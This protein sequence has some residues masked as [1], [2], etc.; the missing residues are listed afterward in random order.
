MFC[1]F[2]K[3][4]KK[5]THN[6]TAKNGKSVAKRLP[7]RLPRLSL[8]GS[9]RGAV[10]HLGPEGFPRPFPMPRMTSNCPNL[11]PKMQPLTLELSAK[12][13]PPQDGSSPRNAHHVA[14]RSPKSGPNSKLSTVQ[15]LC[16][17][18]RML[19]LLR[20]GFLRVVHA[21]SLFWKFDAFQALQL[22][23]GSSP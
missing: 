8:I 23:F 6:W 9:F 4:S 10:G 20:L 22:G 5:H 13:F 11:T 19:S 21:R 17:V 15:N 7:N 18:V 3:A 1:T 16:A 2:Q 14:T 12:L